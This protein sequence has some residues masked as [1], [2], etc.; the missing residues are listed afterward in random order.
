MSWTVTGDL[1]TYVA[2]AG[3]FLRA[4]LAENTVPLTVIET[5]R[6]QGP[7]AFG[8]DPLFGWW[9]ADGVRGACIQTGAYPLLLSAMPE[10]AAESLADILVGRRLPGV[11]GAAP[12]VRAFAAGWE[13]RTEA[14][15]CVLM[16][17]RLYRLESLEMPPLPSGGPRVAG[18]SDRDLVREWFAAIE[19][20]AGGAAENLRLVDD[21]LNYGGVLLWEFEDEPVSLA[22]RTRVVEGMTRIG[23]VYTPPGRRRQGYGAAV[24]AALTRSALDTGAG[25]VVLFTDLA[26]PT[27]NRVYQRIGYRALSDR[28][29]LGFAER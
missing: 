22:A 1:E 4:D 12:A 16:R 14:I 25:Q 24:T 5:L 8:P 19:Q 13:R 6:A 20:E 23:P 29:V 10:H 11:N 18:A 9:H 21:R 15:A 7:D 17:Q 26:N 2:E 3:P 28:L 27:S